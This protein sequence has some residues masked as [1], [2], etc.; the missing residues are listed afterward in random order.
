M[1]DELVLQDYNYSIYR[2]EFE[3]TKKGEK[4]ISDII[5]KFY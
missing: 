1:G 5:K 2:I 4:N 3:L